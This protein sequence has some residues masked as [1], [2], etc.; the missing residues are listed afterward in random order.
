[1]ECWPGVFEEDWS[2][3][4]RSANALGLDSSMGCYLDRQQVAQTSCF[5]KA[6]AFPREL[7]KIPQ[8]FQRRETLRYP[9]EWI[10]TRRALRSATASQP[11]SNSMG[12]LSPGARPGPRGMFTL[13]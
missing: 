2:A 4:E 7:A 5:W 13:M 6:A 10:C 11:R 3:V 1:M 8:S 9:L 12:T